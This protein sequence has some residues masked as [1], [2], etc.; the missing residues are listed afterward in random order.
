ME[1]QNETLR[2]DDCTIHQKPIEYF[3]LEKDCKN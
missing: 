1:K 2:I 3:C